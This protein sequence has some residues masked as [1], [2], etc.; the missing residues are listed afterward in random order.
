MLRSSLQFLKTSDTYYP[1][2]HKS[3]LTVTS[4][5]KNMLQKSVGSHNDSIFYGY[6]ING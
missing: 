3:A 4:P 1:L 5:N 2:M 6:Q